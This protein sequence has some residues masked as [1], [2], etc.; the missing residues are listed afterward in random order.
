MSK[1]EIGSN[2]KATKNKYMYRSAKY[3][4]LKALKNKFQTMTIYSFEAYAYSFA[5]I[6]CKKLSKKNSSKKI[7]NM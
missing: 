5:M 3:M 7:Q 6:C 4:T 1:I 2:P